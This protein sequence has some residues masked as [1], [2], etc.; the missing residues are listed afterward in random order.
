MSMIPESPLMILDWC[1]FKISM[2]LPNSSGAVF[3]CFIRAQTALCMDSQMQLGGLT[4][5]RYSFLTCHCL[6]IALRDV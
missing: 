2:L 1:Y 4:E 5:V 3:Y 6:E